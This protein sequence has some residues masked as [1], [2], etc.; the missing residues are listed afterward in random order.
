MRLALAIL[1]ICSILAGCSSPA[2][3]RRDSVSRA[4]PVP[5]PEMWVGPIAAP[6]LYWEQYTT[7]TNR[8]GGWVIESTSVWPPQW[9]AVTNLSR[10]TSNS[11][12]VRL[13]ITTDRPQMFYRVAAKP[14]TKN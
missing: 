11:I 10:D 2:M 14:W 4:V 9:T 3:A 7:L 6:W 8:C 5:L 13:H 1:I 12:A